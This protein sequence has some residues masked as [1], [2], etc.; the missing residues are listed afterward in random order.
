MPTIVYIYLVE[1]IITVT[2]YCPERH[3]LGA[4]TSDRADTRLI[5]DLG[6][7]ISLRA[8]TSL[9]SALFHVL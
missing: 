6:S 7:M 5:S 2:R 8:D 3:P 9:T 4:A 1:L